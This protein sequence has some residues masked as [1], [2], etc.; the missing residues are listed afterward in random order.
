MALKPLGAVGNALKEHVLQGFTFSSEEE[1]VDVEGTIPNHGS[2]TLTPS[3]SEQILSEGYYDNVTVEGDVNLQEGN[4]KSGESIFGVTGTFSQTPSL[5]S[6]HSQEYEQNSSFSGSRNESVSAGDII[7]MTFSI[8]NFRGDP[9]NTPSANTFQVDG[10]S[11]DVAGRG[12]SGGRADPYHGY[13][14][15][16]YVVPTGGTSTISWSHSDSP[17]TASVSYFVIET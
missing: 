4:I 1:G 13:F 3:T 5:K 6:S 15:G 14:H 7:T 8:S 11:V 16:S 9:V 10:N 12:R 2:E 17:S